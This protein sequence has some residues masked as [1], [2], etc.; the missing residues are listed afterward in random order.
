MPSGPSERARMDPY[1]LLM[2][3]PGQPKESFLIFQP[4]VPVGAGGGVL[5]QWEDGRL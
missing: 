1:Y 4:F 5:R 2:M 3:L